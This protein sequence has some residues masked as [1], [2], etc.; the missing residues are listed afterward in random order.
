MAVTAT[1]QTTA[2]GSSWDGFNGALWQREINVRAFIQ[3]NYTPYDGDASLP[4]ARHRPHA[5]HLGQAEGAVRRGAEEGRARH[6][7][8][9]ELDHGA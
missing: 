1:Q 3:L 8:G 2:A 4:G 9:A 7:A 5:G 6:L